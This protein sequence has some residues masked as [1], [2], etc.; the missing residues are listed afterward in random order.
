MAVV[1]LYRCQPL[2]VAIGL[3][4]VYQALWPWRRCR[5]YMVILGGVGISFTVVSI[6]ITKP[7]WLVIRSW[8]MK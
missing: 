4:S 7:L 6:G 2:T 5:Q 3:Y 1:V 8:V